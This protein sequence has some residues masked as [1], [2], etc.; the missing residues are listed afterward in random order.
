MFDELREDY[1]DIQLGIPDNHTR[2]VWIRGLLIG[3]VS[4]IG[5]L[6]RNIWGDTSFII[7]YIACISF[8]VCCYTA[9]FDSTLNKLRGLPWYYLGRDSVW[10]RFLSNFNKET[11]A[12][13]KIIIFL[14]GLTL[15]I[16]L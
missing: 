9:F 10:D 11:V 15:Y 6:W 7:N 13:G 4:V 8:S 12:I 3:L 5:A 1:E 14:V 2:D 16:Y